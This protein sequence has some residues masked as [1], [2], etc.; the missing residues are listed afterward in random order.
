[1][2]IL[3]TI[4]LSLCITVHINAQISAD[5]ATTRAIQYLQGIRPT[6]IGTVTTQMPDGN[7]YSIQSAD[8]QDS[9]KSSIVKKKNGETDVSIEK[10]YSTLEAAELDMNA[11]IGVA[12]K[13][14]PALEEQKSSNPNLNS[15]VIKRVTFADMNTGAFFFLTGITRL[16]TGG[17]YLMLTNFILTGAAATQQDGQIKKLSSGNDG[18]RPL[19][20]TKALYKN[21]Y[22]NI[23]FAIDSLDVDAVLDFTSKG[24]DLNRDYNFKTP[25]YP[26]INANALETAINPGENEHF[27][28]STRIKKRIE[29]IKILIENNAD[30]NRPNSIGDRPLNRACFYHP[31]ALSI[32]FYEEVANILL[33]HK[34]NPNLIGDSETP[35]LDAISN[36]DEKLV[37]MLIEYGANKTMKDKYGYTPVKIALEELDI[38]KKNKKSSPEVREQSVAIMNNIIAMLQ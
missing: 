1:M 33:Q 7:I 32:P 35:L 22:E 8:L 4:F 10:K 23:V 28:D 17:K 13:M 31:N 9:S 37:K 25:K 11:M 16:N 38:C 15:N 3:I 2:K 24:T 29:I 12:K 26:S 6:F 27:D 20:Q 30:V 36:R 14:Y 34:A 5:E 19:T 21:P 18:I